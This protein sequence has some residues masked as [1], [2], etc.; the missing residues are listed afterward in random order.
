MVS[1]NL[2][3]VAWVTGAI[4]SIGIGLMI[5]DFRLILAASSSAAG[6]SAI[7]RTAGLVGVLTGALI[8]GLIKRRKPAWGSAFF[9]GL[10]VAIVNIGFSVLVYSSTYAMGYIA[11][12]VYGVVGIA[13]AS[14]GSI[15]L[16]VR[17][18]D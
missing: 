13:A 15:R 5:V 7:L 17:K 3:H 10:I 18:A 8:A 14:L 9:E 16:P 11:W 6:G 4:V 12:I 1:L 2:D